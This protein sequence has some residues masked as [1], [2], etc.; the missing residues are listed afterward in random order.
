MAKPTPT[1]LAAKLSKRNMNHLRRMT[2]T[3]GGE[4]RVAETVKR[5][6]VREGLATCRG[7]DDGFLCT[8]TDLGRAVVAA[9]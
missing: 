7:Y 6:L 2:H 3:V 5:V 9:A 1:A 8:I 4:V